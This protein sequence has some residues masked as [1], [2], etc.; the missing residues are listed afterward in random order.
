MVLVDADR[1][2]CHQLKQALV[3]LYQQLPKKPTCVLFRIAI[4]ESESWFLADRDAIHSAYPRAHLNKLPRQPDVV[5]G[6]WEKLA[7]VLGR[8]SEECYGSDKIEWATKI[9][10]ELDLTDPRSPSLRA[11][12]NGIDSLVRAHDP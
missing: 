1:D 7:E 6:A 11:F 10:P 3:G 12:V 4:E 5:I 2:D 9:A 8:K